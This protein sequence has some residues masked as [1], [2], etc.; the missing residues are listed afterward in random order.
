[1]R[2]ISRIY[3]ICNEIAPL[4]QEKCPDWRFM[5]L[6]NNFM[7]WLGSDGFYLE[8]DKFIEYFKKFMEEI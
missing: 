8:D 6:L 7:A 2:D 3:K 5:Q 4:W 1:M